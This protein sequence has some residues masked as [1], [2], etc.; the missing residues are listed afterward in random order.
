MKYFSENQVAGCITA[1]FLLGLAI[2]IVAGATI[3]WYLA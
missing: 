2:G 3:V 1:G